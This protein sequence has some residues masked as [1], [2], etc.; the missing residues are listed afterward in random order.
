MFSQPPGDQRKHTR[1]S[2]VF[3]TRPGK[4]A[5]LEPME[6]LSE[7]VSEAVRVPENAKFQTGGATAGEWFARRIKNQRIK[8]RTVNVESLRVVLDTYYE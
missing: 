1:W 6:D 4:L 7:M 8:N 3:F 5:V 2:L